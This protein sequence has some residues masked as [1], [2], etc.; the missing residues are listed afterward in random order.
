M[1]DAGPQ[2]PNLGSPAVDN[3]LLPAASSVGA[4]AL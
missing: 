3:T 1:Q 4:A 2:G